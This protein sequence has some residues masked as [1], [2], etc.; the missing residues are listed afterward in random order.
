LFTMIWETLITCL[1]VT[2]IPMSKPPF[3]TDVL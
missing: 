2:K 1:Q 3:L